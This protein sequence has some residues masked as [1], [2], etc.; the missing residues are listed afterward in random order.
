MKFRE[1]LESGSKDAQHKK[2]SGFCFEGLGIGM[3]FREYLELGSKDAQ[4]KKVFGFRF[5]GLG[6]GNKFREYGVATISRL[7]KIIGLF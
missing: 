7:L 2:V 1:Y 4:H 3:K 5:E 6:I